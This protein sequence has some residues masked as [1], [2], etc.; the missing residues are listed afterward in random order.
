[1]R[2]ELKKID[3]QTMGAKAKETARKLSEEEKQIRILKVAI[4]IQPAS[5]SPLSPSSVS[6]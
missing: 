3:E 1:M 5:P 6:S 4:V 2:E